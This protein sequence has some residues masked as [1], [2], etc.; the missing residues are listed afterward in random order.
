MERRKA[1]AGGEQ[2]D[3]HSP[4]ALTQEPIIRMRAP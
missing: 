1:D 4:A 3:R 2:D